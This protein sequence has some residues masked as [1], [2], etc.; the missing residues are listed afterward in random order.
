MSERRGLRLSSEQ[1]EHDPD[2]HEPREVDH[3]LLLKYEKMIGQPIN[4]TDSHVR[5]QPARIPRS[6][7]RGLSCRVGVN[8]KA[9]SAAQVFM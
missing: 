2:A 1:S 9:G 6:R 3:E 8:A 4:Y 5:L 7:V